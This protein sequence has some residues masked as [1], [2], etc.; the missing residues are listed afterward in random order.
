M[1]TNLMG[2]PIVAAIW[3]PAKARGGDG[4][5]TLFS[6]RLHFFLK[7]D[8]SCMICW[9]ADDFSCRMGGAEIANSKEFNGISTQLPECVLYLPTISFL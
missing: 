3:G 8:C 9:S 6:G 4:F 2:T 1:M 5:Q 7:D